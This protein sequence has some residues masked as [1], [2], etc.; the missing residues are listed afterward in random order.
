[1]RSKSSKPAKSPRATKTAVLLVDDHPILRRGLAELLNSEPD[2]RVCGQAH[3]PQTAL[4]AL[5]KD[6]PDLAIIDIGLQG[7]MDGL[8]LVKAIAREHPTI[9]TLVLSMHD[10]LV[11]GE[12]ALRA[13]A[14]GYVTKQELDDTILI[15]IRRV[16]KGERYLSNKCA[17]YF[18]DKFLECGP[19]A[20]RDG[21]VGLLSDREL[22][23]FRL[24]G[25]GR[26]TR[27][28]AS[29]LGLSIKTVESHLEHIKNKMAFQSGRDLTRGAAVWIESNGSGI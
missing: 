7:G 10:E 21:S 24:I 22:E 13:G 14:R 26:T 12:R 3:S 28:V 19:T 29:Y 18:A 16:L 5:R 6:M 9:L 1:M 11:Y 23:V 27:Q 15:A 2:L 25:A 20:E 17:S 4:A 8:G